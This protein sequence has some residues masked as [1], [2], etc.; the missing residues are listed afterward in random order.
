M[1]T[2]GNKSTLKIMSL[3]IDQKSL[4]KKLH[5][6]KNEIKKWEGGGEEGRKQWTAH[7]FSFQSSYLH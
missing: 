1:Q 5:R 4:I 7:S 6:K 3:N 2:A